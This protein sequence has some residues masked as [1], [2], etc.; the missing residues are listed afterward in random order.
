M[1]QQLMKQFLKLTIAGGV[2]VAIGGVLVAVDGNSG[3]VK[4]AEADILALNFAPASKSEKFVESM[5]SLGMEKPRVYDWNGNKMFFSTMET[6][7][8]PKQVLSDF[9]RKFVEDGVNSHAYNDVGPSVADFADASGWEDLPQDQRQAKSAIV[10]SKYERTS[11]YFNGG[12]VPTVVSSNYVA[13]AGME[14]KGSAKDGFDFLKEVKNRGS[15]RLTDSVG[16]ARYIEA[17]QEG[18]KTR[19]TATWTDDKVDF[20]KFRGQGDGI[21]FTEDVPGCVG[22]DRLMRFV[23]ESEKGYAANVFFSGQEV[24]QVVAFYD[25]AL[26]NRG[27]KVAPSTLAMRAARDKGWME[28]DGSELVSF[29][30]NGDFMTLLVFKTPEGRTS[31]QLIEAP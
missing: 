15:K 31:V 24:D 19:V 21:G 5:K 26:T 6:D 16:V 25:Q 3:S 20:N 22:C 12:M 18:S 13:M 28:D 29:A 27:W 9:Q 4:P 10:G 17:F 7:R 8:T 14:S 23:G 2:I 30:R 1:I 11:D